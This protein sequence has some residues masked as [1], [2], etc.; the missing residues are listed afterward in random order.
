[1]TLILIFFLTVSGFAQH[2]DQPPN[3]ARQINHF[4][5]SAYELY[6][7]DLIFGNPNTDGLRQPIYRIENFQDYLYKVV[8]VESG[9]LLISYLAGEKVVFSKYGKLWAVN[10]RN[11]SEN[12]VLSGMGDHGSIEYHESDIFHEG[13]LLTIS[14][15]NHQYLTLESQQ[16]IHGYSME[17]TLNWS[18]RYPYGDLNSEEAF[19]S[20]D[21]TL[22]I[23]NQPNVRV[24]ALD[25]ATGKELW[26]FEGKYQAR[27]I[28]FALNSNVILFDGYYSKVGIINRR[29]KKLYELDKPG[30]LRATTFINNTSLVSG[31]LVIPDLA[32]EERR[33]RLPGR[34]VSGAGQAVTP[35]TW[36]NEGTYFAIV[37]AYW[38]KLEAP[39]S[40]VERYRVDVVSAD[41]RDMGFF[42]P[43][44]KEKLD[45]AQIQI[46]ISNEGSEVL[47]IGRESEGLQFICREYSISL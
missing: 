9:A 5:T 26:K 37:Y 36:S 17:G 25:M 38:E 8:D 15:L 19:L 10:Y 42:F 45:D 28:P 16:T 4:Q 46:Q 23:I 1:M 39:D 27:V 7:S 24:Q 44:I 13:D 34:L 3:F 43:R 41:G 20:S 47:F 33:V 31:T 12:N 30:D 32:K 21:E 18:Y 14:E 6:A 29:G 22:L 2:Y 11:N 35:I 40:T